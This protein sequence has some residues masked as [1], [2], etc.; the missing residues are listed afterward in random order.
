MN[1]INII[2]DSALPLRRLLP[3]IISKA[4]TLNVIA[5]FLSLFLMNLVFAAESEE[6]VATTLNFD[7]KQLDQ[8]LKGEFVTFK[9]DEETPKE[10]AIGI[11]MYLSTPPD[12]VIS[13]FKQND[14]AKV[15]PDVLIY[16]EIPKNPDKDSFHDFRFIPDQIEEVN[17]L[18]SAK[19]GYKFNLSEEEIKSLNALKEKSVYWD[20]PQLIEAASLHY[21]EILLKRL[22]EYQ[23]Q[24]LKG[25]KPYARKNGAADPAQELAIAAKTSKWLKKF[26]SSIQ[27]IWINYPVP[28]L[29]GMEEHFTWFNREIEGRPTAILSHRVLF[30]SDRNAL[31][32]SRQFFVGHTYNSSQLLIGCLPYHN[33]SVVFYVHRTSTDRVAGTGQ[34][35]KHTIGRKQMEEKMIINFKGLRSSVQPSKS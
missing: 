14:L 7:E 22:Q 6:S 32:L 20:K 33:G 11:A 1:Q 18:L 35:L 9:V 27:K 26:P 29:P 23:K 15:D 3:N 10:L 12:K 8:L 31:I 30:S 19:V 13:F 28:F 2:R 25:I 16:H 24:G 5:F 17:E 21:Q 34:K 4:I